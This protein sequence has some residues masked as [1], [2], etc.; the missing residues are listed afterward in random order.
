[1]VTLV[2]AENGLSQMDFR[3]SFYSLE[4][5]AA[6]ARKGKPPRRMRHYA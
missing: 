4:T 5:F 1:M 2:A 6:A 3:R